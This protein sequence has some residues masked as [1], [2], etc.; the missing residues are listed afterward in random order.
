VNVHDRL[1]AAEKAKQEQELMAALQA[2]N[3]N[4][5]FTDFEAAVQNRAERE[6]AQ[7]LQ[8]TRECEHGFVG[9]PSDKRDAQRR[10]RAAC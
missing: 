3:L 2:F 4:R 10:A 7:R 8:I 6:L 9:L 1:L 5:S